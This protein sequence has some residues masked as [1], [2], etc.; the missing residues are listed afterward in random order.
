MNLFQELTSMF[1]RNQFVVKPPKGT[2]YFPLGIHKGN[3]RGSIT[4]YPEVS[5][6][7]LKEVA[8]Y[9][10]TVNDQNVFQKIA[11]SGQSDVEAD[12]TNDTVTFVAGTGMTLTTDQGSDS[13]TFTNSAPNVDQNLYETIAIQNSSGT[14]GIAATNKTD[15]FTFKE[16]SGIL[17]NDDAANQ[18]V[19]IGV[20][21]D[22]L[23]VARGMSSTI[24]HLVANGQG[25]YRIQ[26][27]MTNKTTGSPNEN[28]TS[29]GPQLIVFSRQQSAKTNQGGLPWNL[30]YNQFSPAL[31][32]GYD[33]SLGLGS[34]TTGLRV[35]MEE[36][37]K[38]VLARQGSANTLNNSFTIASF[39][40]GQLKSFRMPLR[41]RVDNA[42]SSPGNG[43]IRLQVISAA[44]GA[45]GSPDSS[46]DANILPSTVYVY[47]RDTTLTSSKMGG[48]PFNLLWAG[49][50]TSFAKFQN[51][52]AAYT[53]GCD[54][55]FSGNSG[56]DITRK[57]E[58]FFQDEI[59]SLGRFSSLK[60]TD[61]RVV[62]ED[63]PTSDPVSKGVLWN[64]N[65]T[66]KISAG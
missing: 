64:D 41:M 18:T 8:N 16:G 54:Y 29:V 37:V 36:S 62:F 13:I 57:Y 40:V 48:P 61:S 10:A 12:A 20:K 7:T 21:E 30:Y 3:R 25:D 59:A 58:L 26:I 38:D 65:G 45:S 11:V 4:K 35:L 46:V 5:L 1:S 6:V 60:V 34:S 33:A 44:S 2:D 28:D 22:E 66:L 23:P 49:K 31:D 43:T 63:L 39:D 9:I 50:D 53:A 14:T 32:P 42:G 52:G 19:S 56:G 17:L 27:H 51:D 55:V 15:T 47:F 24:N